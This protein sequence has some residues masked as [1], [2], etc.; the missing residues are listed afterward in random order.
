MYINASWKLALIGPTTFKSSRRYHRA[1]LASSARLSELARI[2]SVGWIAK[3]A[4]K[5]RW[6]GGGT[7]AGTGGIDVF[8]ELMRDVNKVKA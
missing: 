6:W 3:V 7:E 4:A 1:K 5:A 8:P 2:V